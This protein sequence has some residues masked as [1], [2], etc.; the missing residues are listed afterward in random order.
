MI[1]KGNFN[2][3]EVLSY[4]RPSECSMMPYVLDDCD[5]VPCK[6]YGSGK[7]PNPLVRHGLRE[8]LGH[9]S[10]NQRDKQSVPYA[11]EELFNEL[12]PECCTQ[13]MITEQMVTHLRRSS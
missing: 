8:K 12:V 11:Y 6:A 7:F 4:D 3:S 10:T 1:M 13:Q 2:W 5:G 9:L